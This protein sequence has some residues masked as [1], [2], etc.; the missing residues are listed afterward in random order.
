[1]AFAWIPVAL[2][3][4]W[5]ARLVRRAP[6]GPVDAVDTAQ[7]HGMVEDLPD[8]ASRPSG[9]ERVFQGAQRLWWLIL[10]PVTA[11]VLVAGTTPLPDYLPIYAL[12]TG[13]AKG[14]SLLHRVL[15]PGKDGLHVVRD[16]VA[17]GSYLDDHA[18]WFPR[19]W[20]G[21]VYREKVLKGGFFRLPDQKE[22]LLYLQ[23]PAGTDVKVTSQQ[24]MKFEQAILPVASGARATS[25]AFGNQAVLRIKFDDPL[26]KTEIPT[27]YRLALV[28]VADV[29][30][31]SSIF[32]RG[33]SDRPYVKGNFGGSGLNSLVKITGYNSKHLNAIA[34]AALARLKRQRRV[35][36]ARITS[37]TRFGRGVQEETVLTIDRDALARHNLSVLEVVGYIRRLL[38]SD[39]PWN[40]LVDGK[41][42]RM[43]LAFDDADDIQYSDVA[44]KTIVNARGEKV[45]LMDLVSLETRPMKGSITRE[46]Q[47][48]TMFLNWEYVGTDKMRRNYIRKTL[49]EIQVPYGYT[50]EEATQEFFTQEEEEDLR[51]TIL[52]AVV[53]I[54]MILAALFESVSLP[55]LV[56]LS[57]PLALSGVF[58]AFW[59]REA[60]FDSSARIGLVLLFGIVVNNAILLVSR[61]RTEASLILRARLGGDPEGNAALFPGL[62][63]QLGGSDLIR[64]PA[65]ERAA[66]LRRAVARGT[67]VRLRSILLTSSTTIVGLIPLL[68]KFGQSEGQDIWE[69]LALSSIGGL[70]SS[71]VL[72]VLALPPLYYAC[73]RI[74]WGALGILSFVRRRLR[75]PGSKEHP[76][77]RPAPGI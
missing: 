33:F 8:L 40:M 2:N 38:G 53:F 36:N 66:L 42:Q 54:F 14:G 50:A 9:I 32:I 52:L 70:V 49:A 35:R 5:A 34:D 16:S 43:Q 21:Y 11:V 20:I 77:P 23:M 69:N 31:G 29:T 24:L 1:V 44:G 12:S 46:N 73:I 60:T 67:Q 71:T 10:P 65:S 25:N 18:A 62:R 3:Q 56:L 13:T 4:G 17:L 55:V 26:L 7:I 22:L 19:D 6:D 30:G 39:T 63:K 57:L 48:Y 61:F 58:T 51:L 59:V 74:K 68:V 47:R 72:L 75:R 41:R 45:K 64:I 27:A 37:G 28:D 15:S 76:V